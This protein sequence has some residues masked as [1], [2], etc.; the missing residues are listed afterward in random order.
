MDSGDVGEG[1]SC[2]GCGRIAEKEHEG[3]EDPVDCVKE[4]SYRGERLCRKWMRMG[5]ST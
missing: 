2:W 3:L 1:E 4:Q 5:I